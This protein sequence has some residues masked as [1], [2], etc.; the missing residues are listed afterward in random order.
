MSCGWT[1]PYS[2]DPGINLIA[3][4]GADGWTKDPLDSAQDGPLNHRRTPALLAPAASAV[5]AGTFLD[6]EGGFLSLTATG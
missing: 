4:H 5:G 6:V 1:Y 2:T 3:K